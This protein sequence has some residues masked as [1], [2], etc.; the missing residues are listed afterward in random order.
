MGFSGETKT[1]NTRD[2]N[3]GDSKTVTLWKTLMLRHEAPG[4]LLNDDAFKQGG[5]ILA[6]AQDR[7]ILRKP[8]AIVTALDQA[9]ETASEDDQGAPPVGVDG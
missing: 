7:W 3:T 4:D 8:E 1:V 2:A 9:P 5:R 6:R